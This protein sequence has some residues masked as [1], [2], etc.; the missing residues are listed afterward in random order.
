MS[1][2]SIS[3]QV[4]YSI[5]FWG[6]K[7]E[8]LFHKQKKKENNEATMT[9]NAGVYFTLLAFLKH[10]GARRTIQVYN[11]INYGLT[12]TFFPFLFFSFIVLSSL[13]RLEVFIA[14]LH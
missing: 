12:V 14:I 2:L 6:K 5:F 4:V 1:F 7:T 8:N 9:L 11:V 10:L 3:Q 13:S